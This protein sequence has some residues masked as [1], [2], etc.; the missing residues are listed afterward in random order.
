M[1][2]VSGPSRTVQMV[3]FGWCCQLWSGGAG[4]V[5]DNLRLHVSDDIIQIVKVHVHET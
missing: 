5:R 3:S 2:T 4:V 1:V